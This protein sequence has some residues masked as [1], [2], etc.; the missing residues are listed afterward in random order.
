MAAICRTLN[1]KTL[2]LGR[3]P[4]VVLIAA[5]A[6]PS[7]HGAERAP[8][9]IAHVPVYAVAGRF[10]GWPA[11]HGIWAW[12]D[13][14]VVGFS[15]GHYMDLGPKR[16]AIARD[17]PEEHLLARSRDGGRT[18]AIENPGRQG[19]LVGTRGMRHGTI[20]TDVSEPEPIPCPGGVDF[21]HPDFAMTARMGGIDA[22]TSRIYYSTDRAKTWKGPFSLPLFGQ[23]G[24]A[25]RT[26]Y[27]VNG[28]HECLLFLTASKANRKEGR[29]I[30]AGTI[31]GGKTWSFI[32]N[33]G[34][35]PTGYAIM[36]ATVRLAPGKILTTIRCREG[37]KSWIDAYR[38]SDDGK[39]WN[40]LSRPAPDC[41]EGNPP[42][43]I[44]LRDGQL[45]LTYGFRAEPF[46]I[47]ARF[48][49]DGGQ[50]WTKP[51]ILRDDGASRDL[52]YPR[53][54]Q[55]P[56]GKIVTIYYFHDKTGVDRTIQATIWDPGI[57]N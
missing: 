8:T 45:C 6:A 23:P 48:S 43:L 9:V 29:V 32:A 14:I 2:P 57:G 35:E 55:R 16:H 54:V 50:T 13:E 42:A 39:N 15:A 11:N 20:P 7:A 24:I 10:G 52:G 19:T 40:Y 47:H 31:D 34:P 22:G 1:M 18:W 51:F 12:G 33:I 53:T 28:K 5:L 38:S 46:G 49:S 25:A 30:C 26:D 36:P 44:R 3:M 4:F 21:T 17:K 27:L 56:D 37:D 41:G